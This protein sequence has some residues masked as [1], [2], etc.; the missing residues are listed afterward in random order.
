M[1]DDASLPEVIQ[2]SGPGVAGLEDEPPMYHFDVPPEDCDELIQDPVGYLAK[3]DLTRDI[4]PQGDIVFTLEGY[5][6]TWVPG[7]G[8]VDREQP[9]DYATKG[10]CCHTRHG[11]LCCR[12]W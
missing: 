5:G 2:I 11:V 7:E 9:A 3:L 6:E 4:A 8:W 10:C 12:Y 1:V